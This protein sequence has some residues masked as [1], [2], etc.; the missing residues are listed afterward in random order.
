M[1]E[2]FADDLHCVHTMVNRYFNDVFV[3]DVATSTFG[4]VS[5]SAT[6]EPCLLSPGCGP[7]PLNNNVPQ[8]SVHGRELFVVGGEADVRSICGEEYQHYPRL[9][10]QGTITAVER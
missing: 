9:A 10:L 2:L 7:L 5:A 1:K 6:V 4:A 3:F 8:T